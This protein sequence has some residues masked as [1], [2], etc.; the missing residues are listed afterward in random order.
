[1]P[2]ASG[3]IYRCSDPECGCEIQILRGPE[4]HRMEDEADIQIIRCSCGLEMKKF[5][6]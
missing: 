1:M 3:E 2:I 5:Q 4:I 6:P